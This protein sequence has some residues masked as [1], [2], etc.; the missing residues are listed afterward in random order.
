V[1][2]SK[3]RDECSTGKDAEGS[4]RDLI[5]ELSQHLPG[6]IQDGRCPGRDSNRGSAKYKTRELLLHQST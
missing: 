2:K 6:E 3:M 5:E 1:S 4:A